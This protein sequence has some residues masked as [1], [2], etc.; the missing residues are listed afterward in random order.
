[1]DGFGDLSASLIGIVLRIVEN[2]GAESLEL[3]GRG[4]G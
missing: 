2:A 3:A 1:V 4:G